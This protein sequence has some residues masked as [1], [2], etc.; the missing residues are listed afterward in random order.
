MRNEGEQK[1]S[2]YRRLIAWQ[3]AV[4]FTVAVYELVTL[5]PAH[6]QYGLRAQLTR[7]AVSVPSNIAG[8]SSRGGAKEFIQFLNIA[9]GSIAEVETQIE[10]SVRT[11]MLPEANALRSLDLAIE[12]KRLVLALRRSLVR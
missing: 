6:E 1:A 5:L 3:R 9:L 12:T 11:K 10:I 2:A 8:G 4:D 7:A